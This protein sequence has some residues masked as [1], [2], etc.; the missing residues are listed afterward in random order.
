LIQSL[1]IFGGNDHQMAKIGIA[2]NAGDRIKSDCLVQVERVSSG[3]ITINLDSKVEKLYGRS[4]REL[5]IR[6]LEHFGLAHARVE[7]RDSGALEFVI[8]ARLEAALKQVIDSDRSYLLD[9]KVQRSARGRRDRFRFTRL[10]LPGNTPGMMLNAGV[11][12]PCG[13]ILDLEDAV[14]PAKKQEARFLVRN[15]LQSVDFYGAERMVRINQL[16]D[17]L[18]DL[19][20]VVPM[21]PELILIPKVESPGEIHKVNEHIDKLAGSHEIYLMPIVESALGVEHAFEIAG[22]AENIVAMAIGL[23]DY[24][25][26]LGVGRTSSGDESLYAGLHLLR[27]LKF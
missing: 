11:H 13:I 6:M 15:A 10:Y 3:G 12:D 7:I 20:Y 22:S 21:E 27:L 19:D 16:P 23:E 2:G 17:G 4:I 9:S 5:A 8:A 24:T 26:D 1:V 14:A 18:T 25:A